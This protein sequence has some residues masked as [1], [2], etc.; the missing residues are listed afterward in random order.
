MTIKRVSFCISADG[1]NRELFFI[2][3]SDTTGEL[4]IFF[5]RA[6]Y[7][8]FN[9]KGDGVPAGKLISEQRLSVHTSRDSAL[10]INT[11]KR[12]YRVG[13]SLNTGVLYTK[14][15]K[16]KSG[17]A[18]LLSRSCPHLGQAH[19]VPKE[20]KNSQ[21]VSLGSYNPKLF[22]LI[23]SVFVCHPDLEF[24][25]YGADGVCYTQHR[26]GKFRIVLMWSFLG[27]PS[28]GPGQWFWIQNDP[29][30]AGFND[31]LSEFYSVKLYLNHR[32]F[33]KHRWLCAIDDENLRNE[34]AAIAQFFQYASPE[35]L[36]YEDWRGRVAIACLFPFPT[37]KLDDD[38]EARRA[39][40]YDYPTF[41]ITSGP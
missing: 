35:S 13:E 41:D 14:A 1:A 27:L 38:E 7:S 19:Y 33:L 34:L 8:N 20:S 28:I 23:Y 32:S 21:V 40:G 16:N 10:G 22:V 29:N 11:I 6:L 15:I 31:G 24:N 26:F 36:E 4:K 9:N 39:D 37:Y 12:T 18:L 3:E 30:S 17:F 25:W 2:A 5:R